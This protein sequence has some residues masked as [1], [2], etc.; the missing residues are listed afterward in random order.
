MA[1]DTKG[2][3]LRLKP[4]N[5]EWVKAYATVHKTSMNN[6]IE[7]LIED[8]RERGIPLIVL[9]EQVDLRLRRLVNA[10]RA[11]EQQQ[12]RRDDEREQDI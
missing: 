2:F 8:R 12:A 11:A 3:A 10:A 1:T 7:Q 6:A 4:E 9:L 5:H